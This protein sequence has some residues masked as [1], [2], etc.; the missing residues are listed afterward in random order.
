MLNKIRIVWDDLRETSGYNDPDV[1]PVIRL[2]LAIALLVIVASTAGCGSGGDPFTLNPAGP[3]PLALSVSAQ[4]PRTPQE[5]AA[6][7][8]FRVIVQL[9]DEPSRTILTGGY[10]GYGQTDIGWSDNGHMRPGQ[11]TVRVWMERADGVADPTLPSQTL[12]VGVNNAGVFSPSD[13]LNV[14]LQ[15]N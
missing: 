11:H 8:G 6:D 4:F 1:Q 9:N 7:P 14:N 13:H 15:A 5:G 10:N 2:F 3:W 12:V